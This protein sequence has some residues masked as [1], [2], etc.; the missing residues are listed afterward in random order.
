MIFM[1]M[2][3]PLI[4]NNIPIRI[5][6]LIPSGYTNYQ[7]SIEVQYS[8]LLVT[9]LYWLVAHPTYGFSS[10]HVSKLCYAKQRVRFLDLYQ[11]LVNI[12]QYWSILEN[13]ESGWGTTSRSFR[14]SKEQVPSRA[15]YSLLGLCIVSWCVPTPI[16]PP[17]WHSHMNILHS[18]MNI[19]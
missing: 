1:L 3:M 2:T 9:N 13:S 4:A 17:P 7:H 8:I 6:Y 16:Y 15:L 10:T 12:C 19:K 14:C 18:H 5:Q 11:Y